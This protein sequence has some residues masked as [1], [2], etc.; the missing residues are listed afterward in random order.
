M[1][2]AYAPVVF[3]ARYV[4]SALTGLADADLVAIED[5][6]QIDIFVV[7]YYLRLT[8]SSVHVRPMA[9][10]AHKEM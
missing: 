8:F 5:S 4:L 10:D 3:T 6:N 1:H 7:A 9:L 2:I